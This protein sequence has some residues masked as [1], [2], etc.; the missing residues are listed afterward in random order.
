MNEQPTLRHL[1]VPLDG[2]RLAEQAIPFAQALVDLA[3]KITLLQVVPD[4]E[5][6]HGLLG[7]QIATPA[8]VRAAYEQAASQYLNGAVKLVAAGVIAEPH[9]AVGDP[10]EQI[11]YF[12][13]TE[14]V[15]LIVMASHGRG[16]VGRW[17][18]GS[19]AD[20]VARASTVPVLIV[21]PP[22]A[23]APPAAV[24]LR[25]VVAP[26]D[27]SELAAEALPVAAVYAKRLGVPVH[28]VQAVD[29]AALLPSV[30]PGPVPGL[31]VTGEVYDKMIDEL[32]SQAEKTLREG[33]DQLAQAGVAVTT[34]VTIGPAIAV[35]S[36]AT[37]PG[38]VLVLT[39]HGRGGFTRWLMGSVA[40]RLI[41]TGAV[42]VVLVPASTRIAAMGNGTLVRG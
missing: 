9:I 32:Q 34:K 40:E 16:A 26:L 3:G 14:S 7:K 36:E 10:E 21:H 29:L 31:A 8:E 30:T 5:P 39:S 2:S 37:G 33:A 15:D 20:K 1:V 35:I 28:L 22:D 18:F 17:M 13:A 23:E 12:A 6:I 41:R 24:T 11:L 42:P 27:G 25:R 38:D 4:P 19:V